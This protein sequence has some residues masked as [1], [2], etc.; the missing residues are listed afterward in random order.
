[1]ITILGSTLEPD[2]AKIKQIVWVLQ[3]SVDELKEKW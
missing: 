1:M 2:W 3:L